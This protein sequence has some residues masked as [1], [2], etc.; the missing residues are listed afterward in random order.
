MIDFI[1][2]HCGFYP[3]EKCGGL[4]D[5][6]FLYILIF[7][8]SS[9]S[10][11][12]YYWVGNSAGCITKNF[13]SASCW[14]TSIDGLGGAGTPSTAVDIAIFE[15]SSTHQN[16]NC[17]VDVESTIDQLLINVGGNGY[18]GTITVVEDIEVN[19]YDHRTGTVS[20]TTGD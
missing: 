3:S 16:A 1:V 8:Q 14:A 20:I 6:R 11:A 13:S 17:N 7:L 2:L 10:A 12:T 18:T 4:V 19:T 15:S 9:L 5:M